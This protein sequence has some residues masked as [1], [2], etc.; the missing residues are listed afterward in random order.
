M[1]KSTPITAQGLN[2]LNHS[3]QKEIVELKDIINKKN[4]TITRLEKELSETTGIATKLKDI[5]QNITNLK[6]YETKLKVKLRPLGVR[7]VQ[8]Y[9]E[10]YAIKY[11]QNKDDDL[12]PYIDEE[13]NSEFTIIDFVRQFGNY[14]KLI[15]HGLFEEDIQLVVEKANN[16]TDENAD[17]EYDET[18]LEAHV[19]RS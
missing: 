9:N 13:G 7:A 6:F 18:Y 12:G 19:P 8:H 5:V 1:A 17:G 14:T 2:A 4:D 3:Y 11:A 15:D 10:E 16:E